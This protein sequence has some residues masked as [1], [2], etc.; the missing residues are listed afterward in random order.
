MPLNFCSR[1]YKYSDL[2]LSEDTS[3]TANSALLEKDYVERDS[4]PFYN[5]P[6]PW[7]ISTVCLLL[8][9]LALGLRLASLQRF[10]TYSTGF[11]TEFS[12]HFTKM[13]TK[14]LLT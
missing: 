6:L 12:K 7:I 4:T 10:G 13:R 3:E 8:F 5:K 2:A 14:A 11:V 1:G 9:N